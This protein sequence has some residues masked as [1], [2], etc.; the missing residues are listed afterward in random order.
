MYSLSKF[1]LLE[2]RRGFS[3]NCRI[4]LLWP[5]HGEKK[6]ASSL[7]IMMMQSRNEKEKWAWRATFMEWRCAKKKSFLYERKYQTCT[8]FVVILWRMREY[9]FSFL[10]MQTVLTVRN[11][12]NDFWLLLTVIKKVILMYNTTR[13]S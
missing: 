11:K 6:K 2:Y 5:T 9:H 7:R 1:Y 13:S 8:D 4:S 3:A 10:V 12:G